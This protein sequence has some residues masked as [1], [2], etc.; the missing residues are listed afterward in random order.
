MIPLDQ[1]YL[2]AAHHSDKSTA[3]PNTSEP[4]KSNDQRNRRSDRDEEYRP[5]DQHDHHLG[6]HIPSSTVC[7]LNVW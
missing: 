6:T 5:D 1:D 7:S 4:A 3:K 2:R